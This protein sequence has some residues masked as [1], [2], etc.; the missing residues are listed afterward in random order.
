MLNVWYAEEIIGNVPKCLLLKA[1]NIEIQLSTG[2]YFI[3]HKNNIIRL[4]RGI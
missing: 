2:D 3:G 1:L 4:I